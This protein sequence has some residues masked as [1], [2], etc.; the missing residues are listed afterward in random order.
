MRSITELL[1]QLDIPYR[2]GGTHHHVR[3][4]WIGVDCPF[5]SPGWGKFRMGIPEG[6]PVVASCWTCGLHKI[7]ETLSELTGFGWDKCRQL[8]GQL[9]WGKA[10]EAWPEDGRPKKLEKPEYVKEILPAHRSYLERRKFDPDHIASLWDVGGVGVSKNNPWSLFIPIYQKGAMV[11]WTCR[12]IGKRW[13]RYHMIEDREAILPR[14][15][16]LYGL[17]YCRH[18]AIVVEGPTDVWRIGPGAVATMGVKFSKS[19]T[20]ALSEFPTRVI[21]YDN[22]EEAQYMAHKLCWLLEGFPGETYRVVLDCKDPGEAT[23]QQVAEL[24]KR[25]L[26]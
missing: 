16:L 10:T 7:T 25:F 26:E 22:E 21:C 2:E 19:Q 18:A 1:K 13:D 17:D 4:G 6:R 8:L 5:C 15:K 23:R 24:R 9:D 12:T 20:I 11:S 3:Y 14:N